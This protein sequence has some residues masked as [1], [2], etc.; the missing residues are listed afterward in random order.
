MIAVMIMGVCLATGSGVALI[1]LLL[2]QIFQHLFAIRAEE[3]AC[4]AQYGRSYQEYMQTVPRYF[5]IF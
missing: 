2:A 3:Q 5:V 1:F 4:L